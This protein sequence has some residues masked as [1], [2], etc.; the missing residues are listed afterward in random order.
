MIQAHIYSWWVLKG[1]TIRGSLVPYVNNFVIINTL[2]G[3]LHIWLTS[4]N[5]VRNERVDA[6]FGTGWLVYGAGMLT[7]S[8]PSCQG[9]WSRL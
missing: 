8:E 7:G 1:C 3:I 6:E 4:F 2:D 9:E 5:I